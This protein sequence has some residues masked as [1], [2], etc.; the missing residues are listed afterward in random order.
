[1]RFIFKYLILAL[2][3][4]TIAEAQENQV[5]AKIGTIE[6]T[7]DEFMARYELTPQLLKENQKI[8]EELKLEF[9]YS[10]IAEKLLALYGEQI[11]LD[12]SVIVKQSLK[13]FEEM[14]VRDALYKKVVQE[15]AQLKTDSLLNFYLSNAN[16]VKMIYIY[17]DNNTEINKI[18]SLLKLGIP[19]DSLYSELNSGRTDTFSVSVG[20]IKEDVENKLFSLPDGAFSSP[21]EMDDGWYI[22]KIL[23]RYNPIITKSKGW[24]SDFKNSK[25]IA[26]ERSEF[27]FYKE[28]LKNFFSNKEVKINAKLLRNISSQVYSILS[29]RIDQNQTFYNRALLVNDIAFIELKMGKD[30]LVQPIVEMSNSFITIG[31]YL[32]FLRFEN[33]TVDT[34]DY[35]FVFKSLSNK[36]KNFIEYKMLANE[37]YLL[38]LQNSVEVKKQVKMWKENY[39]MQLVT[40]MFIDSASVS[41]DEIIAFYNERKNGSLRNKEV[42]IVEIFTDSLEIVENVLKSVE[43]NK[44]FIELAKKYSQKFD[45]NVKNLESGFFNVNSKGQLGQI[46]SKMKVGEVYGPIKIQ[47]DFLIFKLIA[48]REDS[49]LLKNN[50][51]Q[52]K[53]ELKR[54]LGFLKKQ[55]SFNKF[56]GNLANKYGVDIFKE[57]LKNI[58]VTSHHSIVYNYLGFGGR[59]LAVPLL[60]VNM[61]WVPEWKSNPENIQ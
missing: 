25:R 7:S 48:V 49:L 9:L 21:I 50:F 45:G 36:L 46:A 5:L 42:N 17:S 24:E 32:N 29:Q 43:D 16:N 1:M 12:T 59:V 54:E 28:Y 44:D 34:L 51:T 30:S 41:D 22:F 39:F 27:S 31:D 61:E 3:F 8:K 20:Q 40:S 6:I 37:G 57:K 47:E 52:I 26:K 38:G 33:F 19:F 4:L 18:Y 15:K 60:N 35:L 2:P 13:Y 58:L 53:D 14:F 23:K 55:K 56:I 11:R 10:L